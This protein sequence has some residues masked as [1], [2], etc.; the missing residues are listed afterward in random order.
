MSDSRS[1][2]YSVHVLHFTHG[3]RKQK[4]AKDEG[5]T[6]GIFA[7]QSCHRWNITSDL[8]ALLF[9]LLILNSE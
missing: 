2:N 5:E 8:S 7:N 9:V 1:E 3:R 4:V 6:L